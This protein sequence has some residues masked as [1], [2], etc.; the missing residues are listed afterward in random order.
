MKSRL[1]APLVDLLLACFMA[2]LDEET[3]GPVI[4]VSTISELATALMHEGA[5]A[6]D[7]LPAARNRHSLPRA[8]RTNLALR[9]RSVYFS[10][11]PMLPHAKSVTSSARTTRDSKAG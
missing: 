6:A 8:V 7:M 10:A 9:T 1:L 5:V 3:E 11:D 4:T 2:F